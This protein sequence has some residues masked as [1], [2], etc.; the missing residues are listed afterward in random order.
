MVDFLET[1]IKVQ[2]QISMHGGFSEP[3]FNIK[4]YLFSFY[5]DHRKIFVAKI[6]GK[7]KIVHAGWKKMPK[8]FASLEYLPRLLT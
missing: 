6:G 4:K 5:N 8:K 3:L 1:L 2:G 7:K